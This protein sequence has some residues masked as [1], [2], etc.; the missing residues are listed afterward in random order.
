MTMTI[1]IR[2]GG[3]GFSAA[4]LS[5]AGREP[6]SDKPHGMGLGLYLAQATA[7]RLGGTLACRNVASGA[8]VELRI[9]LAALA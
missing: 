3:K 8:E 1:T 4:A 9:P 7:E 2:D 6:W 5:H